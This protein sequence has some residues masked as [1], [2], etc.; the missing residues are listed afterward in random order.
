MQRL[1][2]EWPL[3]AHAPL[4]AS[5]QHMAEDH[6]APA[7]LELI[8]MLAE[9][10]F[11][12]GEAKADEAAGPVLDDAV[13]D[14]PVA[15]VAA[16]AQATLE[17]HGGPA[18][19]WPEPVVGPGKSVDQRFGH[20][21]T[22]RQRAFMDVLDPHETTS[23]GSIAGRG[24]VPRPHSPNSNSTYVLE[25]RKLIWATVGRPARYP[26]QEILD[27]AAQLAARDGPGGATIGA[28]A[29]ALGAPTGSIY[30]RFRSRDVL[31]AELWLQAVESFQADFQAALSGPD[32]REGGLEAALHTPRWVRAHPVPARLLLLHRRED[33]LPG[34]WPAEVVER[35]AEVGRGGEAA[36]RSFARRA[37]RSTNAGALRRARYAVI[38]LPYAAVRPHVHADEP[39]PPIVDEL[40]ASAYGAVMQWPV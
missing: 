14:W 16:L 27:V 38:D 17:A 21:A 40:I 2:Q 4:G 7:V 11:G 35:A 24:A 33:F 19:V 36:L 12:G 26:A 31:L 25:L 20:R 37:L 29:G 13:A 34:G 8:A 5:T 28:I 15:T 23:L 22:G 6:R 39:P 1:E 10:P 9:Q 18:L 3:P 30:H 32:A